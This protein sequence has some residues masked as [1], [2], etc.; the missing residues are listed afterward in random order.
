MTWESL[1]ELCLVLMVFGLIGTVD[2][3]LEE[4]EPIKYFIRM[5]QGMLIYV[6][7]STIGRELGRLL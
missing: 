5:G 1:P 3:R 2:S 6:M 4:G 7:S